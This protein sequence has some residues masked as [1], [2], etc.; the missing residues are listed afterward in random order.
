MDPEYLKMMQSQMPIRTPQG[1]VVFMNRPQPP[2]PKQED[3]GEEKD[4]QKKG[5]DRDIIVEEKVD[6][7]LQIKEEPKSNNQSYRE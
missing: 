5:E 1:N 2:A 7:D 3:K 4:E 6:P